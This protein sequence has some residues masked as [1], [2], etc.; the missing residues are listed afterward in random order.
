[1]N[2][3]IA[4]AAAALGML[5]LAVAGAAVLSSYGTITGAATVKPAISWDILESYSD[6]NTTAT[7]DTYYGLETTYQG[8]TKWIKV[9]IEN[10]ADVTLPVNVSIENDRPAE[11]TVTV[12]DDNK[13]QPLTNPIQVPT[14]DRYIWLQ[15]NFSAGAEPGT[16]GFSIDI[17]PS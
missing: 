1:M 15:H 16:Y 3:K 13:S 8:E 12:F 11:V 6:V 7:N 14:T 5:G 10:A 17:G 9:K 4:I 2:R